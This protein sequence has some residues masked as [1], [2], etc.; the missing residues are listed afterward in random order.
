MAEIGKIQKFL[1]EVEYPMENAR[2]DV[3]WRRV[4]KSVPTYVFEIQIGGEIH[5]TLSKLKHAYGLWNSHIF[6][7]APDSEKT[8]IDGLVN[9]TFHEIR[10]RLRFIAVDKVRDLYERKK[11]YRELEESIGIP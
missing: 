2:L 10:H 4:E 11:A 7:V 3:V 6:I 8:K 1:A 9:G 5:R